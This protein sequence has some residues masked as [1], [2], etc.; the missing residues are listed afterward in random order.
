VAGI[1]IVGTRNVRVDAG[2]LST[3]ALD[4]TAIIAGLGELRAE[5]DRL[6]QSAIAMAALSVAE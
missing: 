6:A 2:G 5:L 1:A 4:A 3:A